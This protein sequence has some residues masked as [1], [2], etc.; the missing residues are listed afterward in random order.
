MRGEKNMKKLIKNTLVFTFFAFIFLAFTSHVSAATIT[1]GD[2]DSLT[3]KI[4]SAASGDVISLNTDIIS[5][6]TIDKNLTIEGN[7]HTLTGYITTTGTSI[8]VKIDNLK[9]YGGIFHKANSS[10]IDLENST[11]NVVKGNNVTDG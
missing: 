7:G 3:D 5:D 1:V 4:A 6:V 10:T 2:G 11:I 8:T 9:L